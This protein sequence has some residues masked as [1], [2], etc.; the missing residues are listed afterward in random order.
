MRWPDRRNTGLC[1]RRIDEIR[2]YAIAGSTKYGIMRSSDRRNTGCCDRRI[3]EI[4]GYA[5]VGS[6]KYGVMRTSDRRNKGSGGRKGRRLRKRRALAPG[7]LGAR[8]EISPFWGGAKKGLQTAPNCVFGHL[9]GGSRGGPTRSEIASP[10]ALGAR[11]EIYPFFGGAKKG[12]SDGL[13]LCFLDTF[14][15]AQGGTHEERNWPM[16]QERPDDDFS[17]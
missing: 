13:K 15:E 5:N 7:A 17:L 3:D 14:L 12:P 2:G 10:G 16:L 8:G 9:S 4:R 11:G 6:M 1:D